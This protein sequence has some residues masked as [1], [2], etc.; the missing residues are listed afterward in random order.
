MDPWRGTTTPDGV[1]NYPGLGYVY[2]KDLESMAMQPE[3]MV[4]VQPPTIVSELALKRN[5]SK[6]KIFLPFGT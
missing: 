6:S 2:D 1:L 3:R 4:I 5:K